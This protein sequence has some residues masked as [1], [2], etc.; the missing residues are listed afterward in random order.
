MTRETGAELVAITSCD[1]RFA[2]PVPVAE[3]AGA[4]ASTVSASPAAVP[5]NGTPSTITVTLRDSDGHPLAGK[6][7]SVAK[8]AGPGAP[9]IDPSVAT[10]D[11]A[12][13]ARFNVSSTTVG[14]N[15]FQATDRSASVVISQTADVVFSTACAVSG[16]DAAGYRCQPAPFSWVDT[17]AG[18][19]ITLSD[20]T[21]S[22]PIV[23][24]FPFSWYGSST[25]TVSIGSNGLLCFASTTGCTSYTPSSPPSTATPND[26]LACYWEDLNPGAGGTVRYATVG[27]SPSRLFVVEFASVPHYGSSTALKRSRPTTPTPAPPTGTRSRSVS[28]DGLIASLAFQIR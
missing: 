4:T 25:S 13:V 7:V 17:S 5:A 3:P 1:E 8:S 20:D 14:T 22:T 2:E 11:A 18:T 19:P 9:T 21:V 12:G 10:T 6:A 24:P 23:L 26:L 15:T 28:P 16:P 27:T